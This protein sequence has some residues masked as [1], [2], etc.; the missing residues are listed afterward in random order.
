LAVLALLIGASAE[1]EIFRWT[2]EKGQPHFTSSREKVP[3]RYRYQLGRTPNDAKGT[4]NIVEGSGE[5]STSPSPNQRLEQLRRQNRDLAKPPQKS[6]GTNRLGPR[7]EPDPI[8][9]PD[10]PYE[11]K[12]NSRGQKCRRIQTQ[13]FR[14]W[15][16]LQKHKDGVPAAAE[17]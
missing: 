12:C 8:V 4:V 17:D 9:K 3:P 15:K 11:M 7:L 16:A 5:P 6:T 13:E 2:D 1:A 14:D 10:Q